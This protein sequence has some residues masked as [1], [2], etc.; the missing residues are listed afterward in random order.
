MKT[1]KFPPCGMNCFICIGYLRSVNPCPGCTGGD[2]N[3]PKHCKLC[4]ITRCSFLARGTRRYCFE[5]EKFPCRRIKQL[6]QRYRTKYGMSMIEN[7]LTIK[8]KGIRAFAKQEEIRWACPACGKTLCVHR[9]ECL[10]CGA[11]RTRK[12]YQAK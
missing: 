3:K 8:D 10:Y 12:K 7:L 2:T 9:D 5:C 1:N 6:D 11:K 4:R